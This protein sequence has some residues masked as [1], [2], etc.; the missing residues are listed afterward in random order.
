LSKIDLIINNSY[1]KINGLNT[2]QMS[3]LKKILS[4]TISDNAAY[5]SNSF[6]NTRRYLID[7]YGNFPTGLLY[8]VDQ[9]LIDQ[10]IELSTREDARSPLLQSRV[11][12]STLKLPYEPYPE[13]VE[14]AKAAFKHKRGIIVAPT[15]VGKSVIAALIVQFLHVRTLIIVPSLEL[16]RQLTKSLSEYFSPEEVGGLGSTIA[17]ENVDALDTNQLLE[18]Y[19]CI[20]ID[21][22]HHSAAATYQKLNKN[23]WKKIFYRFGLTATPFRSQESERL[24][25][26]S[27]LSNVVYRI[28]YQDA[29][30]KGYIVP[31][32]AYYLEIP[33][34]V[35]D[36][37]TWREVYKEL[38][39]KNE[40][41]NKIISELIRR[42]YEF[43]GKTL[44]LVKE[45]EHGKAIAQITGA[46]F[47]YGQDEDCEILINLFKDGKLSA[48]IGTT[49][50]IGEGVDTKPAEYV[51]IAGLGKS[52]NA[53]MQ[54]VGRVMRTYPGKESGKV[55]IFLDRSHKWARAHFKA[56]VK[57]LK[58]EY[59]IIP[60]R[61]EL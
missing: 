21:E 43:K 16:K 41:R 51:I 36:G 2:A 55:I 49:G 57:I 20:I 11:Y 24:L 10:G 45:I 5:Y 6:Y 42:I 35:V 23:A 30:K 13:Q 4:Y 1:S 53:F 25:L 33:K 56:Q 61:L 26:E 14:A 18:G 12:L 7:R 34:Q 39:T 28:E 22:F 38:V 27:V 60:S 8:L 40:V 37:Y 15:G 44:C 48:L 58:E 17:I 52:K 3:K 54:Q 31:I 47:A 29:V 19:D 9:F 50:V 46:G 32:E 59:G